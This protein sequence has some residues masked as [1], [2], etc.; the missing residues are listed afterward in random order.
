MK[1]SVVHQTRYTY[2]LPVVLC[3]N[4]ARLLARAVAGQQCHRSELHIDPL[5]SQLVERSDSFGN[6][7]V[8]FALEAPH[9]HLVITAT[10]EIEIAE[11]QAQ[12][13]WEDSPPWDAVREWLWSADS[14]AWPS[15][16]RQEA[17]PFALDS[18]SVA[19]SVALAEYAAPS[20]PPRRPLLAAVADLVGRIHH[21]F[22]FN[23]ESTTITTPL[24][25][26]LAH[27]S[28]VC[29]D[30]AHLALGCLRSMG[31]AARYVSGYLETVPPPGQA[32]LQGADRSHAWV[33]VYVPG[34]GW[35]DAD[36]TTNQMPAHRH[37]TIAW[38]RDYGDVTPLKGVIF[39]G[40]THTL[41][42][43]VDVVRID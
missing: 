11:A 21:D 22:T 14:H 41:E 43:A 27:R 34:S 38:G 13:D 26:V 12:L 33:A 16:A 31:L 25:E 9:D 35:I 29:Q 30:F 40:G 2:G 17:M 42:V 36:P 39:G 6:R 4:E 10:S 19:T 28:G 23:P 8:Y 3:H 32:R 5:P 24:A 15:A 1:L 18:D 7:V 37:V 20:L